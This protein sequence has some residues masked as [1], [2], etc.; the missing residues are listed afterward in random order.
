MEG[1]FP[2]FH[3]KVTKTSLNQVMKIVLTCCFPFPLFNFLSY[4]QKA[5]CQV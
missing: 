4:A 5:L 1:L 3:G 2:I